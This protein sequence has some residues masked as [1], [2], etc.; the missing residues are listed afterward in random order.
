MFRK[1]QSLL[2]CKRMPHV[3]VDDAMDVLILDTLFTDSPSFSL[4]SFILRFPVPIWS[5]PSPVFTVFF[6]I[7]NPYF[8]SIGYSDIY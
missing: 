1:K 2:S 6:D 5:F 3:D 4:S 7:F 8:S